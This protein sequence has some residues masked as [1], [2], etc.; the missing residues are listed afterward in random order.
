LKKHIKVIELYKI[1]GET[2]MKNLFI[3]GLTLWIFLTACGTSNNAEILE[4][5][6]LEQSTEQEEEILLD[7]VDIMLWF[8]QNNFTVEY[9]VL[10]DSKKKSE[11]TNIVEWVKLV[12]DGQLADIFQFKTM[13]D[14][15]SDSSR[16]RYYV[17]RN[18]MLHLWTGDELLGQIFEKIIRNINKRLD[19]FLFI[20]YNISI[21]KLWRAFY[22]IYG[23]CR[24]STDIENGKQ[25]VAYQVRELKELGATDKTIYIEYE[26]GAKTDRSELNKLLDVLKQGDTIMTTEVS[27]ITRSTKQLCDLISFIQ[28]KQLKLI[29]KNSMTIDCTNGNMD[30]MNKAFLQIAGVFAELERGM[31]SQ[32]VKSGIEN[33]RDKGKKIGRPQ[34]DADDIPSAFYKHYPKYQKGQITKK[35]LSRLCE[36]SYPSIYKYISIVEA[37]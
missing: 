20:C 17:N 30:A 25:D 7:I 22:M 28:E 14:I 1:Q 5:N 19:I 12:I 36:L 4:N 27:R 23:Y 16:D 10:N 37:I 6:V 2:N 18:C 29:I 33:A 34:T 11:Y 3:F 35:D 26:S 31:I 8:K 32:R 9:S 21:T 13:S 24:C 15:P